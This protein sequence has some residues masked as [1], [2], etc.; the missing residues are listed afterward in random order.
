MFF[1]YKGVKKMKVLMLNGSPHEKGCTYTA[2]K[3]VADTLQTY[4]I[5]TEIFQIGKEPITACL[6]CFQRSKW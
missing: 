5:E 2:L 4:G 6:G 1:Y 3:E